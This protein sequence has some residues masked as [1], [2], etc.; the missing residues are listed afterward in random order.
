MKPIYWVLLTDPLHGGIVLKEHPIGIALYPAA[1]ERFC[2]YCTNKLPLQGR[3]QCAGCQKLVYCNY[4][5]RDADMLAHLYECR[6]YKDL[7][8]SYL[9]NSYSMFLLR[10]ISIFGH[11]DE[12]ASLKYDYC[13]PSIQP[14][15][16]FTPIQKIFDLVGHESNRASD[17]VKNQCPI[18]RKALSLLNYTEIYQVFENVIKYQAHKNRCMICGN[19]RAPLHDQARHCCLK[20]PQQW[21]KNC[22]GKEQKKQELINEIKQDWLRK[23][24]KEDREEE[25]KIEQEDE[26]DEK[27]EQEDDDKMKKDDNNESLLDKL[28]KKEEQEKQKQE[29]K[30]KRLKEKEERLNKLRIQ[31]ESEFN[32]EQHPIPRQCII[33]TLIPILGEAQSIADCNAH[34]IFRD[35]G[36]G[37]YH[38]GSM[39]NHSCAPNCNFNSS[40]SFIRRIDC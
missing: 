14:F 10:L 4:K 29:Q 12:F 38:L 34:T 20:Q 5:C 17:Y 25:Q 18:I 33:S 22:V 7:D 24:E 2:A 19:N 39:F 6:A 1:R 21:I 37:M 35:T 23:K 36:F 9:E 15:D 13:F 31:R 40:N 11:N 3:V 28:K 16:S 8:E 30:Q 27:E 32:D 26:E